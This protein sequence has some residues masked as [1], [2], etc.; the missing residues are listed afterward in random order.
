MGLAR[1]VRRRFLGILVVLFS[2]TVTLPV[3][4]IAAYRYLPVPA[5]PLMVIRAVEDGA[6]PAR[7]WVAIEDVPREVLGAIVAAEDNNF[8]SHHG[9]DW[10]AVRDAYEEWEAGGRLRGASTVSMQVARNL[11]LWDGGGAVRKVLEV[12]VT[13]M[14]EALL[15]KRRIL[16]IYLNVAEWGPGV[17]GIEAAAQH[18]F[19]VPAAQLTPQQAAALVAILPAPRAWSPTQPSE[20]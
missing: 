2:L 8:C 3:L 12:Y 11:F 18:H 4:A 15:P 16:E 6:W 13:A 19:G 9:V 20:R 14:V 5:T 10:G 17:F 1:T 7:D